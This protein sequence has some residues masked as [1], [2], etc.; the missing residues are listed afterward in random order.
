MPPA[1]IDGAAGAPDTGLPVFETTAEERGLVQRQLGRCI[2]RLQQYEMQSNYGR[3]YFDTK[4][5]VADARHIERLGAFVCAYLGYLQLPVR[6]VLD[7]GCGVG[8][9][10]A[11]IAKHFP[12]ASYQGVEFSEYLCERCGWERASVVDYRS[13]KPFDLVICQGVLACLSP[14]DLKQALRDLGTLSRGALYMEAVAIEDCER[15][16]V[17][18]D[19]TDPGLFRHKAALYRQGLA[20]HFNQLGG[21]LWFSRKAEVPVFAMECASP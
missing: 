16:V 14:M 12:Q 18:E 13:K 7:I 5:A 15:G 21:G 19:R 11:I 20:P 17:D 8:Q 3:Y 1:Q 9:W 10:Q 6:R 2:L 4:T